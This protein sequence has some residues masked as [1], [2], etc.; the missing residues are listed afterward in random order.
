VTQLRLHNSD[1]DLT[2][3]PQNGGGIVSF[4]AFGE[5]ILVPAPD[6]IRV[7]TDPA[8]FVLVPYCN[9]IAHGKAT[10]EDQSIELAPNLEGETHPLHGEG[11]LSEWNVVASDERVAE[12]SLSY[13]PLSGRWPWVFDAAQRYELTPGGLRHVLS[14]RNMS[15]H[16]MP[17]GLGFHPYFLRMPGDIVEAEVGGIWQTDIEQLPTIHSTVSQGGPWST[18]QLDADVELDHCFTRWE[19]KLRIVRKNVRI[20][21]IA[22][23][24]LGLLHVYAPVGGTFF[25]AEPVSHMPDALNQPDGGSPM[26]VLEPGEVFEAEISYLIEKSA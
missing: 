19:R 7:S 16:P 17:A 13:R 12:L 22:S 21:L 15:E 24:E 11:W 2:V 3:S 9:R 20:T 10:F 25:C 4:D 23:A 26:R 8:A 5:Q 14:V 1:L 6:P 18:G